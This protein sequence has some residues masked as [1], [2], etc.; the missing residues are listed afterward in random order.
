MTLAWVTW[1]PIG[2]FVLIAATFITSYSIAVGLGHVNAFLPYISD[3]G[4]LPPESCIFGQFLN[5]AGFITCIL[6]YIRYLQIR[7]LNNRFR[8]TKC[9]QKLNR[10]G[11][12]AGFL[13][14]LGISMVGNFQETNDIAMHLVG[15]NLAFGVGT[16]YF[17][18]Q[19]AISYKTVPITCNKLLCHFRLVLSIYCIIGYF[20]VFTFAYLSFNA[21][22]G[23]IEDNLKWTSDMPGFGYHLASTIME[24]LL[25]LAFITYILTVTP[26]FRYIGIREPQVEVLISDEILARITPPNQSK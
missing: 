18:I 11:I 2:L 20:G 1:I 7:E 17:C 13:T 16:I 5:I 4:T 22:P 10:W 25:A 24:W 6:A 9:V 8:F 21:K 3:T 26:E 12:W 14:G 15:A 19:C 23:S